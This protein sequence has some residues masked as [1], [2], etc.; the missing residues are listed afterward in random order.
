[1]M[2]YG[3]G[4]GWVSWLFMSLMM[5]IFWGG[6]VSLAVWLFRQREP[7]PP[8]ADPTS[9]LEERFARGEIDAEELESRRRVLQ[10]T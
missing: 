10:K 8:K 3:N 5:V 6:L 7:W 2:W 9:I 1:M 4:G